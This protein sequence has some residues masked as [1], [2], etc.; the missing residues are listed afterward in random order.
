MGLQVRNPRIAR[1]RLERKSPLVSRH[2]ASKSS[3]ALVSHNDNANP[4]RLTPSSAGR[5]DLRGRSGVALLFHRHPLELPVPGIRPSGPCLG[6]M[7]GAAE[8]KPLYAKNQ[9]ERN[10]KYLN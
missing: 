8:R 5:T 2:V 3:S 6:C 7:K 10:F 9:W 4:L 1:L